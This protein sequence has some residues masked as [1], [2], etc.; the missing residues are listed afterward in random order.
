ME[1]APSWYAAMCIFEHKDV[2]PLETVAT[3]ARATVYEER[4]VLLRAES[5][6]AAIAAAE[7]EA[8]EY[9]KQNGA[10]Y[11]GYIMTYQLFDEVIGEGTEVYS[12]MRSSS[13]SVNEFLNHYHDDG[14]EHSQHWGQEDE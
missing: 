3:S 13:L 5:F 8:E 9:A 14:T 2:P 1:T 10:R 11:V 12:L 6:D 4:I 7:A